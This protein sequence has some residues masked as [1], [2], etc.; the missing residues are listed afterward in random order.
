MTHL[1]RD[2]GGPVRAMMIDSSWPS[3]AIAIAWWTF[4]KI[5]RRAGLA[6]WSRP[7]HNI[8]ASP[9]TEL[10][11]RFP[12][13]VLTAWPGNTPEIAGKHYL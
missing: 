11:E 2:F 5:I 10:G 7:F 3:A 8:R 6:P 13:H 9:E 1:Q 4:L 12:I